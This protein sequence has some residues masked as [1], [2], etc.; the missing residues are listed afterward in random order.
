M[1]RDDHAWCLDSPHCMNTM[2]YR[3]SRNIANPDIPHSFTDRSA[4]PECLYPASDATDEASNAD[5]EETSKTNDNSATEK[6]NSNRW[7]ILENHP[8]DLPQH[9]EAVLI[10]AR[11]AIPS[12][13]LVKT[14]PELV[15]TYA[16]GY[17]DILHAKWNVEDV[18]A[19]HPIPK[20]ASEEG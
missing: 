17:Y 16:I 3:H 19:W 15:E 5:E 1:I 12:W 6:S 13:N 14:Y 4:F 7:H 2:C 20:Y 18:I 9:W 8:Y 10:V 11:S